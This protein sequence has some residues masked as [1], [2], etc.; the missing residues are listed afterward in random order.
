[1]DK[2]QSLTSSVLTDIAE[3]RRTEKGKIY[4]KGTVYIQVSACN[5][6]SKDSWMIL[7]DPGCLEDKYAVAIPNIDIEPDYFRIAL[8]EA[9]PEWFAR[10]VGTN[11]NISMDAFKY[12]IVRY[13]EN[14]EQQAKYVEMIRTVE[15]EIALVRE[16]IAA[17]KDIKEWYLSKMFV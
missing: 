7:E 9:T 6:N 13:N 14:K 1:M 16:S 12:F 15:K 4:P 11:I 2:C 3:V 10:Y 17:N 8:E 5:K